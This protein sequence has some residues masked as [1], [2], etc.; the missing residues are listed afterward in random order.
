MLF[1]LSCLSILGVSIACFFVPVPLT[2]NILLHSTLLIIIG[3]INSI[4][5]LIREKISK[6]DFRDDDP[7]V[8]AV[9]W[10]EAYKFPLIGS[11]MLFTLYILVKYCGKEAVSLFLIAYFM[12]IGM[13]SFKGILNNYT[14]IGK[15]RASDPGS[16]K[17]P[18]VLKDVSVL[19][20][21]ISIS[22]FD[23]LCLVCSIACALFY[24]YTKHWTTNN[25]L[26]IIFTLFALENMLLGSFQVGVLMLFGLFFYDIFWVFG[27]DVMETVAKSIDGPIK[28]LFPKKPIIESNSDMSLLGLGDIVIPGIFIALCL[29]YDFISRFNKKTKDRSF[30][31]VYEF[32]NSIPKP[33][34]WSCIVGYITGMIT[35]VLVM[36][37]FK[38]GQPALLYLVPGCVGSVLICAFVRR[39]VKKVYHYNEDEELEQIV[40]ETKRQLKEKH[41]DKPNAEK[42][43]TKKAK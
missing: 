37:I 32:F 4:K 21:D 6:V 36:L 11:F 22:K 23:L 8:E 28:L 13:E 40:D 16:I 9:G 18:I 5:F 29:R 1:Y 7:I 25:F 33:Y 41:G 38:R 31:K 2:L 30:E 17:Y 10:K 26:G 14:R 34:F 39:E 42:V 20:Y 24:V 27:T 3:C 15:S 35:T 12:F 43:E 19:G